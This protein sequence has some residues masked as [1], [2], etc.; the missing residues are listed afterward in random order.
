MTRL[1]L[2][3]VFKTYGA[4][5][6]LTHISF[7]IEDGDK[8]GLIGENSSGKSTLLKLITGQE[9]PDSGTIF[10]PRGTKVGYVA[11]QLE[12]AEDRT[13]WVE[14]QSALADLTH[15]EERLRK[16]EL[17]L[18]DPK[19]ADDQI[20]MERALARY[21]KLQQDFESQGAIRHSRG[22]TRS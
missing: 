6:V 5:P 1:D 15:L 12:I 10:R 14:V 4:N 7:K 11:Q 19:L 2:H 18:A 13:V 21:S 3:E 8:V 9:P 20:G 22:L 16:A 17:D